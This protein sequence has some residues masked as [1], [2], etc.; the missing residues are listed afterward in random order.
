VLSENERVAAMVAALQGGDLIE[1]GRLLNASHVSLRDDY[2][3]ST[4]AVEA[5]RARLLEAGALGARVI[6][7]GFGGHVLGL[8]PPGAPPP[9]GAH[10]VRPGEGARL[11]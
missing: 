8:L 10:D 5:A 7:G 4:P 11:L 6:G 2:E 3:V 1:A 9:Q